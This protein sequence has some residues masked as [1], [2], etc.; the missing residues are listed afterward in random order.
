SNRQ[1]EGE[2]ATSESRARARALGP[3]D[4]AAG[5]RV[6]EEHALAREQWM[7]ARAG[8]PAAA[9]AAAQGRQGLATRL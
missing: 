5:Q 1:R 4:Q 2:Q 8:T 9:E 3:H 7:K 6:V